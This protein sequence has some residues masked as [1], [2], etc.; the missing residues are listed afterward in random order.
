[1]CVFIG[2]IL[3]FF[4]ACFVLNEPLCVDKTDMLFAFEILYCQSG[5]VD[6]AYHRLNL[7]VVRV[8]CA[9]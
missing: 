4:V 9:Y 2:F 7:N 5:D 6:G 1:M 3:F 8:M